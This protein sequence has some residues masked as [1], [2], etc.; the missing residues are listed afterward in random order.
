MLR[1]H[2]EE[3]DSSTKIRLEGKLA[4]PWVEELKDCWQRTQDQTNEAHVLTVELDEVNYIDGR[5]ISLLETMYQNGVQLAARGTH[6]R[7]LIEQ[8]QEQAV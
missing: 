3:Q 6:S 8:I 5:G 2:I 1:I 7:Y 4:G